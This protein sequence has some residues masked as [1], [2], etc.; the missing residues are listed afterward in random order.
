MVVPTTRVRK[1]QQWRRRVVQI[2]PGSSAELSGVDSRAT[3]RRAAVFT[4]S[5]G[6]PRE[7]MT[8]PRCAAQLT[9]A[10]PSAPDRSAWRLFTGCV[11]ARR[12]LQSK[13]GESIQHP[14]GATLKLTEAGSADGPAGLRPDWW[15]AAPRLHA[16]HGCP[17]RSRRR[18][19]A[20]RGT[21][22]ACTPTCFRQVRSSMYRRQV[23]TGGGDV[24][25]PVRRNESHEGGAT[26]R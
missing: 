25:T 12:E 22:M 13:T 8:R 19:R 1:F 4:G 18:G 6:I 11:A 24:A 21:N 15:E 14:G 16:P 3:D 20:C 5:G 9:E 17:G 2:R 7:R 10:P 26:A 23:S